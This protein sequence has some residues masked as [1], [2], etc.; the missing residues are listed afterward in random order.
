MADFVGVNPAILAGFRLEMRSRCRFGRFWGTV[1]CG[2][3][4]VRVQSGPAA[5]ADLPDLRLDRLPFSVLV[6]HQT[7]I[8]TRSTWIRLAFFMACA[9]S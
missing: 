5:G 1:I 3:E 9:R 7:G 4:T 6:E 2:Q 8:G